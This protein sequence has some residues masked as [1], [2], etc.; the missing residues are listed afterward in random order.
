MMNNLK[1]PRALQDTE[2]GHEMFYLLNWNKNIQYLCKFKFN[3]N[4]IENLPVYI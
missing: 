4:I 3:D 1:E 2:S